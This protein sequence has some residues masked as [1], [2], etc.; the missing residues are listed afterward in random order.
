MQPELLDGMEEELSHDYE[1]PLAGMPAPPDDWPLMGDIS[2]I[3]PGMSG[4]DDD[5][6]FLS[7]NVAGL[8]FRD[9]SEVLEGFELNSQQPLHTPN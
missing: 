3:P 1:P 7:C 4:G 9:T 2:V 5:R 8:Q 6:L